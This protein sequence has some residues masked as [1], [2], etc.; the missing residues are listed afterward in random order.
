MCPPSAC[1]YSLLLIYK[2]L[3]SDTQPQPECLLLWLYSAVSHQCAAG[4]RKSN[5][6]FSRCNQVNSQLEYTCCVNATLIINKCFRRRN[7]NN[8][9]T[10]WL[11]STAIA[12]AIL[13]F[14][15]NHNQSRSTEQPGIRRLRWATFT[16]LGV[17]LHS[18]TCAW[19][20]HTCLA[21]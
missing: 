17:H 18:S 15:Y 1:V 4:I 13:S 2:K 9:A 5:T 12:K 8:W 19:V 11:Q 6:R 21:M 3:L 16:P 20:W 7:N 10:W 14:D